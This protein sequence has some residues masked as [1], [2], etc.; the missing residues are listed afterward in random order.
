MPQL[1]ILTPVAS[2]FHFEVTFFDDKH[3]DATGLRAQRKKQ[4]IRHRQLQLFDTSLIASRRYDHSRD[5]FRRDC[6]WHANSIN[7]VLLYA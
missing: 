5:E 4:R 3:I 2:L 1:F 6:S 7:T